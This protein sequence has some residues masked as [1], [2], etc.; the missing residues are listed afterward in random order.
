ME[1]QPALNKFPCDLQLQPQAKL[2]GILQMGCG[3]KATC[4]K[5]CV[6]KRKHSLP[7]VWQGKAV[8]YVC[9]LQVVRSFLEQLSLQQTRANS[10]LSFCPFHLPWP[11]SCCKPTT[12]T[13][14]RATWAYALAAG[15]GLS[16]SC[17][18]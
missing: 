9:S 6:G 11:C 15:E 3:G 2:S 17:L 10:R 14:Q 18:I 4:G 13:P 1:T 12:S 5:S 7:A 16:P 8:G